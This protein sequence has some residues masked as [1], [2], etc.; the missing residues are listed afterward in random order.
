MQRNAL[1]IAAVAAFSLLLGSS[2]IAAP[3]FECPDDLGSAGGAYEDN[4]YT[5]EFRSWN[6]E[7]HAQ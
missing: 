4:R 6:W 5:A 3:R 1:R 2:L 7:E